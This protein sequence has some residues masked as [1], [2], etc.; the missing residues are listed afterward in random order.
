MIVVNNKNASKILK[1]AIKALKK[2]PKKG[3]ENLSDE[4]LYDIINGGMCI[5][6]KGWKKK[7][8]RI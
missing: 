3:I 8:K 5:R 1:D 7:Y 6:L 4:E 2:L